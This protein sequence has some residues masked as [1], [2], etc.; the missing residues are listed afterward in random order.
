MFSLPI[1]WY[2]KSWDRPCV[3]IYQI[4]KLPKKNSICLVT[5]WNLFIIKKWKFRIFSI[6]EIWEIWLKFSLNILHIRAF[7][8]IFFHIGIGTRFP[9]IGKNSWMYTRKE[10]FPKIFLI[11]WSKMVKARK[12]PLL[13]NGKNHI[14]QFEL[15]WTFAN[16][17]NHCNW[18][19]SPSVHAFQ[20]VGLF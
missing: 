2:R 16:K 10:H 12:K 13:C 15:C 18:T 14:F 4:W 7:L 6:F 8:P 9:Q 3:A 5:H 11:F 17:K 20:K 1:L 19:D